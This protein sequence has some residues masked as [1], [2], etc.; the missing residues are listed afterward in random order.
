MRTVWG[1]AFGVAAGL[2]GAGLLWLVASPPRGEPVLLLPPPT[3]APIAVHVAG[4]V[5]TPGLYTLQPGARVAAALAAAGG[6]REDAQAE[7]INLAARLV[8]GAQVQVPARPATLPGT[9]SGTAQPPAPTGQT[10]RI[11][12]NTASAA[13]LEQLPGIG[14]VTAGKIVAYRE[15]RGPFTS[16]DQI[17]RVSGIGPAIFAGLE[18]LVTVSDPP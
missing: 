16:V 6:L 7:A 9:P 10:G 18:D 4:A 2:L 17:Q 1:V 15:E 3:A 8:D 5:R 12:L 14:P 11:D 13:E